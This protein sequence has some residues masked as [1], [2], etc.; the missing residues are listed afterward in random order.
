LLEAF[1]LFLKAVPGAELVIVGVG[2]LEAELKK[3]TLGLGI[4]N[5]VRW[6]GK[7]SDVPAVMKS[8]D[9]F[10]LTSI[11]EGFGLVLLEAMAAGI[12][13]VASRV[14]AIPE[15]LDNGNCRIQSKIVSPKTL[16]QSPNTKSIEK[17]R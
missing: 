12:P 11:Y 6:L 10:A 4:E 3:M 17:S 2:P 15:V 7:R 13:V 9:V 14:S 8:F 5:R 1:S 16:L